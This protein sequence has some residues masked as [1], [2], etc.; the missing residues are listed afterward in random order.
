MHFAAKCSMVTLNMGYKMRRATKRVTITIEQEVFDKVEFVQKN[1]R[2]KST[3]SMIA[4]LLEEAL[5]NYD[6]PAEPKLI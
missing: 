5:E 2:V 1:E 3:S 6:D 4:R